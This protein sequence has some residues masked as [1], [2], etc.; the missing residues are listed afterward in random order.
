M[1]DGVN[2]LWQEKSDDISDTAIAFLASSF[3]LRT[4]NA[5]FSSQSVELRS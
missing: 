2:L 3:H 1:S 4:Q 5:K